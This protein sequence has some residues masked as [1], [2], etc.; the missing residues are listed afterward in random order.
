VHVARAAYEE[1]DSILTIGLSPYANHD[2]ISALLAIRPPSYLHPRLGIRAKTQFAMESAHSVFVFEMDLA[3]VTAPP[4]D[5][6]IPVVSFA[7]APL[8]AAAPETHPAAHKGHLY[9]MV[10]SPK[11]LGA[12]R[13]RG[14]LLPVLA[15]RC[16]GA[17]QHPGSP[18]QRDFE[19][20]SSE[21]DK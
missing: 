18:L 16:G 1:S 7:Q 21:I 11:M 10:C 8:Y 4:P 20:T 9:L 5:A 15:A 17:R 14:L 19:P 12:G 13:E 3:Q 2:W 6:Q